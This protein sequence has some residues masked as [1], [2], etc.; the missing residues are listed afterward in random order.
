[1][2]IVNFATGHYL[3]GQQRLCKSVYPYRYFAVDNYPAIN[4]PT[5][6][7]SPYQFKIHAIEKAFEKDDIVLWCDASLWVVG[8]LSIIENII[9]QD[10]YFMEEA[11]HYVGRWTNEHARNYFKLTEEEAK[12]ETGGLTM[13]SAG[14]IGLDKNS[15]IAMEFFRQ[16]KASALAGC[17]KGSYENHRHDMTC[18]SIIAQRLGMKYQ[19]GGKHMAYIGQGYSEPEPGIVFKLQ[20]L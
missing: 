3:A 2:I 5:H 8:D 1:M 11:G 17:F 4:S 9:K 14:L 19:R 10:G 7:E 6:S 13:F 18:A 20:G 15:D 16:W 12:Q